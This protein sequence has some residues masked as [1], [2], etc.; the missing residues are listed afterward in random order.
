MAEKIELILSVQD[1]QFLQGMRRAGAVSDKVKD[2]MSGVGGSVVKLN[3]AFELAAKGLRV[4]SKAVGVTAS[5]ISTT[6]KAASDMQEEVQKFSVV[7]SDISDSANQMARDLSDSFGL[8]RLEATRLLGA[9]GDLLTGFGFAQSEALSFSNQI[10]ELA[11]DLASFTNFS[12]GAQGA[13]EALTKALLGETESVKSLGIVIRETDVQTR[14]A[15]KGLKNLTGE[16]LLQAKAQE[17]LNIIMEQSKNAQGDFARSS[18]SL[19]NQQRILSAQFENLNTTIGE[20]FL[21]AMTKLTSAAVVIVKRFEGWSEVNKGVVSKQFLNGLKLILESLQASIKVVNFLTRAFLE[22]KAGFAEYISFML[23][24]NRLIIDSF[25]IVGKAI[26]VIFLAIAEDIIGKVQEIVSVFDNFSSIIPDKIQKPFN[27]ARQSVNEFKDRISEAKEET[28]VLAKSELSIRLDAMAKSFKQTAF[29]AVNT[30]DK[31]DQFAQK[32]LEVSEALGNT[33]FSPKSDDQ[34]GGE[35]S[36]DSGGG[37]TGIP[38]VDA[39]ISGA[40]DTAKEMWL[41]AMDQTKQKQEE[42]NKLQVEWQKQIGQNTVQ[43]FQ[44][45]GKSISKVFTDAIF[46]QKS[47][48]EGFK[49]LGK[50][51]LKQFVGSLIEVGVQFAINRV[52]GAISATGLVTQASG[53][54]FANAFASISAIPI[55]GPFIAPA[56]AAS[57]KAATLAGG[58]AGYAEGSDFIPQDMTANIHKGERIVPEKTNRDLTQFLRE[59]VGSTGNKPATNINI[60]IDTMIGDEEFADRMARQISDSVELR[61]QDFRV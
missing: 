22:A 2:S 58:L 30:S 26:K 57:A 35:E 52:L 45:L 59:N 21:P 44:S 12:G 14:L 19:A 31:I 27:K 1:Q 55:V 28:D 42:M 49:E 56:V 50:V 61:N 38:F 29:D 3:Q 51:I 41:E 5:I 11:V 20:A 7:F 10:Q 47:L 24:S 33:I 36:V 23:N 18:G 8:S 15:E 32:A 43:S 34:E 17:R 60:T 13:S 48:S 37:I 53:V 9:T 54:A 40:L 4:F 46:Q 39:A 25:T 16:A 6:T